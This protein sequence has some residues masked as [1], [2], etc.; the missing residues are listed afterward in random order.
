M[1]YNIDVFE[2]KIA[3]F[4]LIVINLND[5]IFNQQRKYFPEVGNQAVIKFKKR[6]YAQLKIQPVIID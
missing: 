4:L 3:S 1:R 6:V 2:I 5:L